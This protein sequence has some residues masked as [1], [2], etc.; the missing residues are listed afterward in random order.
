MKTCPEKVTAWKALDGLVYESHSEA[1]DINEKIEF[2]QFVD[3]NPIYG[4]V[5]GSRID[6]QEL[7]DWIKEHGIKVTIPPIQTS[8][9]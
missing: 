1:L 4:N 7:F 3:S 9:G 2:I 8:D 5:A 6:G